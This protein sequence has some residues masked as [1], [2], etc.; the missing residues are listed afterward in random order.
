M[1]RRYLL[2]L[3]RHVAIYEPEIPRHLHPK[4]QAGSVAAELAQPRGHLWRHRTL[5]GQNLVQHLTGDPELFSR[6]LNAQLQGGEHVLAQQRA[7]MGWRPRWRSL[8][9]M[10][11]CIPPDQYIVAFCQLCVN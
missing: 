4:P 5:F 6:I 3:G 10:F 2:D 9:L 1:Q 11:H 8:S 7:R